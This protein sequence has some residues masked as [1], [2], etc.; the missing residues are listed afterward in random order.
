VL[1]AVVQYNKQI[2]MALFAPVLMQDV[3]ELRPSKLALCMA[4]RALRKKSEWGPPIADVLK[5]IRWATDKIPSGQQVMSDLH[6]NIDKA[7]ENYR[8]WLTP[9]VLKGVVGSYRWE[10]VYLAADY[11]IR[12]VEPVFHTNLR[13]P[14][15]LFHFLAW[16]GGL[17]PD[18]ELRVLFD[19]SNPSVPGL[20]NDKKLIRKSGMSLDAAR[21]ACI[22]GGF[23]QDH[24]CRER[25]PSINDLLELI[26]EEARGNKQYRIHE[27]LD[28]LEL[29]RA[30]VPSLANV[31]GFPAD[32]FAEAVEMVEQYGLLAGDRPDLMRVTGKQLVA[33][34][35]AKLLPPPPE[36]AP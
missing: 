5:A 31:W 8:L 29:W 25:E 14:K 3:A 11:L 19:T 12:D 35:Q 18:P 17:R 13:K 28:A 10:M 4:M 6:Q 1:S 22:E 30:E 34:E 33:R 23:L 24:E 36:A 2:N 16:K 32:V 9:F 27:A 20:G 7:L 21:E 26:A 15:S